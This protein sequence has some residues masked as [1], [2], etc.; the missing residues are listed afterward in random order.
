MSRKTS[1]YWVCVILAGLVVGTSLL[2]QDEP[3]RIRVDVAAV[4]VEA[5]VQ[6][7]SGRALTDLK[8]TDF[9]IYE[10]GQP[11]DIVYFA[12]TQTPRSIL[13][14]FD[15]SGSTESQRP[16]MIQAFN[17]FLALMRPQDRVAIASFAA[18]LQVLVK[19]RNVEGQPKEVTVPATGFA[20]NVYKA[21]EDAAATFKNEKM[22]KGIIV[23]TDGRDTAS[24][25]EIIGK[26]K[27]RDVAEDKQFQK[28]LRNIKKYQI[29]L[30]F[31]AMNTD[32]NRA[33]TPNDGEYDRVAQTL[34]AAAADSYLAGVRIR[35][36]RLAEETG[37]RILYPQTL[38]DVAPLYEAIGRELGL[39]YSLGYT[40]K[41]RVSDG[42]LRRIEVRVR[43]EGLKVTQS[44][45]SYRR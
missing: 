22:R 34:G 35:M 9:E 30:Y 10:D 8:Q 41:N 20:S 44:R 38:P 11:Q 24:L 15:I 23:M 2:A 25:E 21:L 33:V 12:S 6:E 29:P 18:D 42:K 3:F 37:G 1:L 31:V 43:K 28:V 17:V 40:P 14:L 36:E 27:V 5:I 39:S 4:S 13:L 19:W 26:G 7:Q 32:R 16:F 45:D